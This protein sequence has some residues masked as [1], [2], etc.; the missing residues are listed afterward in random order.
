M[1]FAIGGN[2][3]DTGYD[4]SNSLRFNDG[5]SADLRLALG[6]SASG[7]NT[8]A[9]FSFWI[10]RGSLENQ[11]ILYNHYVDANNYFRINLRSHDAGSAPFGIE[12]VNIA[13]GSDAGSRTTNRV[14]RD[15]S[16]WMHIVVSTD[17][18]NSTNEDRVK[19]Y[20]NGTRYQDWASTATWASTFKHFADNANIFI[21]TREGSAQ[22]YDGYIT[23][24]N[25]ID[26]VEYDASFFGEFNDDGVWIPKQYTGGYGNNGHFLQ[27]KQTGTSANSSGIGADTSGNDKHFT[28]TNLAAIDVTTDTCTNNF[29]TLNFLDKASAI[30]TSEGN[31]LASAS[32]SHSAIRGTFGLRSGKWYW[33]N[34]IISI[35][36][37]SAVGVMTADAKLS[38][39]LNSTASRFYRNGGQ[40][41]SNGTE[42]SSYGASFTTNDIIGIALNLDDG[43]ITFFKNGSTQGVAFTDLLSATNESW[44]P[45]IKLFDEA[46]NVNFGNPS[47]SISSGNA[48]GE[49]FGNFEYAPPSG[50]FALNT[51]NLAEYG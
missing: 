45:A 36:G 23:E 12:I 21:G 2:Q 1:P 17:S 35:S 13:G 42:T 22:Y 32:S 16:A 38:D 11:Q 48:D 39:Q 40:K 34:K 30:T 29:C 28:P 33:E 46:I 44:L 49:G 26:G 20:I 27:F 43:E 6:S 24:V 50:F 47:F 25:A 19:L 9:S 7:S 5:D 41:F 14:F 10:K 15:S 4:I 51:K 8:N 3:L 31:T 37:G 18:D